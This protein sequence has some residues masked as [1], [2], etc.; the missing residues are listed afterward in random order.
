MTLFTVAPVFNYTPSIDA[1][2]V[3]VKTSAVFAGRNGYRVQETLTLEVEGKRIKI[4]LGRAHTRMGRAYLGLQAGDHV[5]I[6]GVDHL[7]N[8]QGLSREAISKVH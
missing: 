1:T 4:H 7:H 8:G 5:K 2:V 6:S 3:D